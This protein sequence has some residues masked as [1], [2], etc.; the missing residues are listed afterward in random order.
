[1]NVAEAD[2][3]CNEARPLL[4]ALWAHHAELTPVEGQFWLGIEALKASGVIFFLA[5]ID[6]EAVGT[7][8]YA[9]ASS[10]LKSM[11]VA[12]FA[13]GKGVADALVQ[14]VEDVAKAAGELRLET[15][16]THFAA[17]KFYEKMGF[18]KCKRFGEY[19]DSEYSVC[20]SKTLP[21]TG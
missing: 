5:Y 21:H 10:E 9:S 12:E 6:G 14:K 1:M 11:F 18:K 4:E 20:M 16:P 3:G 7:A 17:I 2:P 19:V 8:A 15:G 13:R